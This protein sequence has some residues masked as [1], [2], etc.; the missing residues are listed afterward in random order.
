MCSSR[1]RDWEGIV[2]SN[3]AAA[4]KQIHRMNVSCDQNR[5]QHEAERLT[6]ENIK[7]LGLN[8][9]LHQGDGGA[10]VSLA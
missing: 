10:H 5:Q 7:I 3:F 6:T 2:F 9:V 4:D 1:K 8:T